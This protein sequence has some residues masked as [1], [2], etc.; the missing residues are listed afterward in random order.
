MQF[1]EQWLRAFVDPKVG[2]TEIAE[3]LTMAG[4]E[5]ESVEP[6]APA[7]ARVVV[8]HVLSVERHPNADKLSVC[9]VDAGTGTDLSIVC[10]AP[11]VVAGMRAPCALE[12]AEL[13][14]GLRIKPTRMR[15][16]E[17]QGMLCSGRELGMSEDHSGLLALPA[18]APV[19]GDV[20]EVLQLDDRRLT[21]KLTPNR[22]DCLSIAG[23]AREVAALTGA[24]LRMPS[25]APVAATID[26]RL[27]VKVSSAAASGPSP[28]WST[29]RTTSC[30]NSAG[31]RTC[32]ISPRSRAASRCAGDNPASRCNCSTGRP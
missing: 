5:V 19:G 16:V 6:V 29:S 20:R 9:T 24:S 15:E 26:D 2:V 32:S 11:N 17:S 14:G 18:D 7:F 4:L 27:P 25:F 8:G 1:S 3:R 12:G 30:W 23:I 28:R 10:G 31:R 13:P 21:I 22:G